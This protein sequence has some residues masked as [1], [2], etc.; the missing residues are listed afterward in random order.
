[1][2]E[3]KV[4]VFQG[5]SFFLH[6]SEFIIYKHKKCWKEGVYKRLRNNYLS[7]LVNNRIVNLLSASRQQRNILLKVKNDSILI[8]IFWKFTIL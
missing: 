2:P 6:S 3:E 4:L 1:M 8:R 5:S 7:F